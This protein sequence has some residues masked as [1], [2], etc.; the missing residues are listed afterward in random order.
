M[1]EKIQVFVPKFR[2][3]ETLGEIRECLERGWTGAGFKTVEIENEWKAYTGHQNAQFLS[4]ATGALHLAVAC[5]KEQGGWAEGDEIVTTALT[6]V[7]TNHV[8]LHERLTPVFADVDA[9]GCL[10]PT[11]VEGKI[12]PRTRAVMFVGLGGNTGRLADVARICRKHGL[13]L[14]LDAAH[15]AGTRLDGVCPGIIHAD[16]ACYSF[17]AVKNLPTGDSGMI[18]FK[19]GDL[20]RMARKMAWLGISR[21]TFSRVGSKGDYKWNYDVEYPGF[22]YNG[23]AVMAAIGLVALR[24]LDEDN[25][26]RRQIAAWYDEL[27]ADDAHI[28]R[29][30]I[31]P[32]CES[33]RHLYQVLADHR[34][35]VLLALYRDEIFPGVHYRDN[36][37]YRMYRAANGSLPRTKDISDRVISLPMHLKLKRS[38]VERIV[39]SLRNA[40]EMAVPAPAP[41]MRVGV[42]G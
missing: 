28:E 26:Y 37:E 2:I 22:K 18:C 34:D 35:E 27:L 4:S 29:I 9:F 15:M 33:S 1:A 3:E 20:D 41:A 40:V 21:D 39:C 38:D 7:S 6:F 5:L 30:P 23:N 42:S 36:T 24:Y 10:D 13:K 17:Q 12:G 32:G 25:A 8:I 14:I 19:D 31:A 11:D 16:V